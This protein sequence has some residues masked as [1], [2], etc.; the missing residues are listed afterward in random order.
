VG[1]PRGRIKGVKGWRGKALKGW[2]GKG[3]EGWGWGGE[4]P[5]QGD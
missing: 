5:E 2:R 4:G 1:S 3:V